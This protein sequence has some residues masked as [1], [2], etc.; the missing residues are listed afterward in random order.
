MINTVLRYFDLQSDQKQL[1][2]GARAGG[3]D[4]L[5]VLPQYL[6]LVVGIA[7]QPFL[8]KYVQTGGWDLGA[9]PGSLLFAVILGLAV[10]PAVYKAALDPTKPLLVQLCAI[11]SAGL[12]WQSL[13]SVGTKAALHIS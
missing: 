5:P 7:V 1:K 11:F 13:L 6:A 3:T 10:F 9:F 12:G 4:T 8:S 2:P